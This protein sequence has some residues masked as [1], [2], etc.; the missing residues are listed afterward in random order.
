[1]S[2]LTILGIDAA[3]TIGQPSGVALVQGQQSGW[4]CLAVAPSYDAFLGL[5]KR[6]PVDWTQAS[7]AG[8]SA[9]VSHLLD[10]AKVISGSSVDV[11]AL[12]MPVATVPFSSRR[13][14]DNEVSTEFGNRWCA[15]HTPNALRPGPLGLALSTA[16][17]DSGYSIS[18]RSEAGSARRLL[19]VY[20][21]PALLS[22]LGRPKRVPYKVSKART[23]WPDLTT[24]Q[25]IEALLSEF[26][27]I[28]AAL[29]AYFG[30]IGLALPRAG[31]VTRLA[32]LK[33]YED[34]LDALVCAW[35]GA[36]HLAGRTVALGDHT[37][38]IWCPADVVFR[39]SK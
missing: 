23:Y 17:A 26:R 35:V 33:R 5:A 10:A 6:Q 24:T 3:W 14:A 36:E 39:R 22:L 11:V 25:R 32:Q 27:S 28:W 2:M 20:P 4:R 30:D 29:V 37:A 9:N 18:T 15:A 38:A 8:S 34:S 19:E 16:L 13:F 12:D 21:H 31:G 1:M 7:F